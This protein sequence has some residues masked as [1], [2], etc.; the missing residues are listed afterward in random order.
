MSLSELHDGEFGDGE[1]SLGFQGKSGM[2][3][4]V[5]VSHWAISLQQAEQLSGSDK[6][7]TEHQMGSDL[8]V[9]DHAPRRECRRGCLSIGH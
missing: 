9:S 4:P 7:D 2:D 6:G 8:G 1:A 3:E 5:K